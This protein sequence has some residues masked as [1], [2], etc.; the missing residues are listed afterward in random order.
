M[1]EVSLERFPAVTCEELRKAVV[2]FATSLARE[3]HKVAARLPQHPPVNPNR[4]A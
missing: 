1:F 2:E 4:S 3:K